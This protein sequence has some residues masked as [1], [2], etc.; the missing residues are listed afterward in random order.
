MEYK[1]NSIY[2]M[3]SN[4]G[5]MKAKIVKIDFIGDL[6]DI[7]FDYTEDSP[8]KPIYNEALDDADFNIPVF[9]LD[10]VKSIKEIT[11]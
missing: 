3:Q 10:K 1:L 2:E 7:H 11:E 9:M 4:S 6:K 8:V 5:I